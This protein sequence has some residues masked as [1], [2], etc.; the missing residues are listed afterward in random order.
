MIL[1][2][3]QYSVDI[4]IISIIIAEQGYGKEK[5]VQRREFENKKINT[6]RNV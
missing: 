5:I 1:I 4:G 3:I 2:W 6:W